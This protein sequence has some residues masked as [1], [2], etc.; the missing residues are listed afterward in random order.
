MDVVK[1]NCILVLTTRS[2]VVKL[3]TPTEL[4]NTKTTPIMS[5]VLVIVDIHITRG[6]Q[7]L[8]VAADYIFEAI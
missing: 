5:A 1:V 3:G 8:S 6:F 4:L 7:I 2:R